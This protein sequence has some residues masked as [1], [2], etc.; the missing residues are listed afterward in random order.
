MMMSFHTLRKAIIPT[1]FL[2]FLVAAPITAAP[3]IVYEVY[4]LLPGDTRENLARRNGLQPHEIIEVDDGPWQAGKRVA[5]PKES[6]EP[7]DSASEQAADDPGAPRVA[8]VVRD[9]VDIRSEAGKGDS[10]FRP[11]EGSKVVVVEE[12]DTHYG[13][14]MADRSTGWMEK[15]A[16][17]VKGPVEDEWLEGLLS[18]ARNDI[19][20]EAFRYLGVPYRYGGDFPYSTDCSL[21]VQQVFRARGVKLPRTAAT[22]AYIGKKISLSHVQPGDRLYFANKRGRIDHTGIYIGSGQFIHA[23]SKRHCVAVDDLA[24]PHLNRLS[25]IRRS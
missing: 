17:S 16:L 12:T 1:A 4:T 10:L 20:Q 15:S 21:L 5:L 18:G 2:L 24:G 9:R 25:V 11:R 14:M 13:V 8:N 7:A 19:V 6:S 23:S 3:T 22:Q